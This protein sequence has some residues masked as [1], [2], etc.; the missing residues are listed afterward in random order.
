MSSPSDI[1]EKILEQHKGWMSFKDFVKEAKNKIN[2]SEREVKRKIAK[3]LQSKIPNEP[4]KIKKMKTGIHTYYGLFR[5]GP[6]ISRGESSKAV[7]ISKEF[8]N[9]LFDLIN[10]VAAENI[11]GNGL[12]A[13]VATRHLVKMLP[14][15]LQKKLKS[16]IDFAEAKLQKVT[17]VTRSL[18][19]E[20]QARAAKPLVEHLIGEIS[21]VLH[22]TIVC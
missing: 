3:A 22:E 4:P 1:L 12:K 2:V 16:E 17:G 6:P 21:S 8:Y 20:H 14:Q 19:A 10:E 7:K 15:P 11:E 9:K 5:W 13:W 18:T